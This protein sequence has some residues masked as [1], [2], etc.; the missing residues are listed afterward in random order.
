MKKKLTGKNKISLEWLIGFFEGEGSFSWG[1]QKDRTSKNKMYRY[2]PSVQICQKDTYI[3]YDIK[4]YL[5][6][7]HMSKSGQNSHMW[8]YRGYNQC[9][10][11]ARKVY[12]KLKTPAKMEQ[13]RRR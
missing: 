1:G 6:F 12:N 11:F 5:G 7:G 8:Q 4:N 3:L 2:Y 9:S 10:Q 13:F